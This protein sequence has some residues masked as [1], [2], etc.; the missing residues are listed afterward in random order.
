MGHNVGLDTC[1]KNIVVVMGL[2]HT[3]KARCGGDDRFSGSSFSMLVRFPMRAYGLFC[4]S[5]N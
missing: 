2:L 4:L 3:W 1:K 5:S